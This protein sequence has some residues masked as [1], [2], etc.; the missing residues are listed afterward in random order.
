M[1]A[2]LFL[3]ACVVL[4]IGSIYMILC[5][6]Y[7]DGII[8]KLGLIIIAAPAAIA[9]YKYFDASLPAVPK[10]AS[11]IALGTAIFFWRHLRRF[12]HFDGSSGCKGADE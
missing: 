11:A 3:V 10:E 8:G 12:W 4:L 6:R 9:I 5:P 7:Q 1:S 2:T